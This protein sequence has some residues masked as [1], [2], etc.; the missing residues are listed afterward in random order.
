MS[1]DL[2]LPGADLVAQGLTDLHAQRHTVN[3]LLVAIG[4]PRLRRL[5]L[6]LPAASR[7]P[8]HPEHQ[9]YDLLASQEPQNAHAS[10]NALIRRLVSYE[11]AC[12]LAI[13]QAN[14]SA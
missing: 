7:L 10:Y 14:R 1:I 11:R 12:E 5:N 6:N 9:L 2:E 8:E 13:E 3:A 4:A